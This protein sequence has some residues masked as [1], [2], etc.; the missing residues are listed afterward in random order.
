MLYRILQVERGSSR[1]HSVEN[2]HWKRLLTS[3]KIDYGLNE[4]EKFWCLSDIVANFFDGV[5]NPRFASVERQ[6]I[7]VYLVTIVCKLI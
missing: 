5:K 4:L 3:R 6:F 7:M 2:S 1:S